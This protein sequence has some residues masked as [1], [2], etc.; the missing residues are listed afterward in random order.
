MKPVILYVKQHADTGL[1]YFGKTTRSDVDAYL[2]SGTRWKRHISKHGKDGVKTVWSSEPF[3]DESLLVDFAQLFSEHFDIVNSD[4]WA[5][6]VVENGVA[7]GALR[8]GAIL[9]ETTKQKLRIKALGRTASNDTK[10]KMSDA[11]LGRPQT[12]RQRMAMREYNLNRHLPSVMCPHCSKVGSYVAMHRWH[13][14]S[15]KHKES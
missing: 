10:K 13:F 12:E 3:T 9:S 15:C 2:G 5:N 7:G 14:D 1:L 8:T 11:R 4:K 6:L